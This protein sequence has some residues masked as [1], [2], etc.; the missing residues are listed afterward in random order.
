MKIIL[1]RGEIISTYQPYRANEKWESTFSCQPDQF[2]EMKFDTMDFSQTALDII[3]IQLLTEE[4]SMFS[5]FVF[6]YNKIK[7]HVIITIYDTLI[8]LSR[9]INGFQRRI[10]LFEL[11]LTQTTFDLLTK[12]PIRTFNHSITT[13]FCC[14]LSAHV[15]FRLKYDSDRFKAETIRCR[16]NRLILFYVSRVALF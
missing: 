11:Y 15:S 10:R 12:R 5:F 3:K 8:I 9:N 4:L 13:G 1:V 7:N 14:E 2:V 16:S 6:F